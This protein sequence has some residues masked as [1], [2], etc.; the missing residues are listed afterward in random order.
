[1]FYTYLT[2][3]LSLL[4]I[5][6]VAY[7]SYS[8]TTWWSYREYSKLSEYRRLSPDFLPNPEIIETMSMG[9]ANTYADI[10]WIN[11]IQYIG[12]NV[13][14]GKEKTFLNPLVSSINQIHPYF[15]EPYNLALILSPN[16]N[17]DKADYEK[18]KKITEQALLIWEKGIANLCDTDKLTRI[19][20]ESF[21]KKLWENNELKNPCLDSMIAYNAAYTASELG[22][23]EKAEYYYKIASLQSGSPGASKFLGPLM[24]AKEWNHREAAEKFLLIAVDG[25]DED[26]YICHTLSLEILKKLKTTP[27]SQVVPD[28]R[29]QED[30][31]IPYQDTTNPLTVSNTA[32]NDSLVRAMK[33]IYLAY[34][35]EV[36]STR[37][38]L[39]TSDELI[40]AKLIKSI[41][42]VKSQDSWN[43]RKQK[44]GIWRYEQPQKQ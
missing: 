29:K 36:G 7:I 42:S 22:E 24:Q 43:I 1:M 38:D 34:I 32:C 11:L 28:L 31:L 14:S 19:K 12:D 23:Q 25:Y 44:D 15:T 9:H 21:G 10:I 27:L 39:Q 17:P 16:V 37:P 4:C 13:F 40:K 5:S 26:P 3:I 2:R 20:K 8:Y 41:P 35:T 6:A 18:N 33:Q 30:R